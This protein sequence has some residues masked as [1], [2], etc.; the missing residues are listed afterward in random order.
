MNHRWNC[1]CLSALAVYCLTG[2]E[3]KI[4][5]FKK[6]AHEE[7]EKGEA[8]GKGDKWYEKQPIVA[9]DI[10]SNLTGFNIEMLFEYTEADGPTC[11]NW[12]PD[13]VKSIVNAEKRVV[14]IQWIEENVSKHD[15]SVTKEKLLTTK[16]NP[17]NT[18]KGAWRQYLTK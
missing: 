18:M 17:K 4:S 11:V 2:S 14:E 5:D 1:P 6:E 15:L 12:C 8:E 13:V 10:D 7:I 3:E 16:W 9:P